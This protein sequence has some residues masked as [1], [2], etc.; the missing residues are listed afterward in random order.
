VQSGVEDPAT[1]QAELDADRA[2]GKAAGVGPTYNKSG[3]SSS[4]SAGVAP[5][6]QQYNVDPRVLQPKGANL[7]EGGDITGSEKNTSFT[8][9]IGSKNDPGL[10]AEQKFA[11]VNAEQPASH[12]GGQRDS[13]VLDQGGY[14]VL[15]REERA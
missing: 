5:T 13:K 4:S 9:E 8:A 15:D 14:E 3:P 11:K 2:G 12:A 1:T 7:K 10:A 6:A